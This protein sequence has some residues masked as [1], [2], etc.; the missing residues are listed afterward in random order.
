MFGLWPHTIAPVVRSLLTFLVALQIALFF[1]LMAS[2]RCAIS[3]LVAL[4][5]LMK[6]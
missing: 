2:Q 3:K 1:F 6:F 5:T 4:K